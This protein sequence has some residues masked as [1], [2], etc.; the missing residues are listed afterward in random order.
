MGLSKTLRA[1][2]SSFHASEGAHGPGGSSGWQV[3]LPL[4]AH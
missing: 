2:Q 3:R 4:T 1:E